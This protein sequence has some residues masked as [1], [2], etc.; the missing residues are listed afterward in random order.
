MATM[1]LQLWKKNRRRTLFTFLLSGVVYGI[2]YSLVLVTIIPYLEK[3]VKSEKPLF[4]YGLCISI[5]N[6]VAVL[7]DLVIGRIA[8]RSRN[9]KLAVCM[10]LLFGILGNVLYAVYFSPILLI[11]GRA[12]VGIHESIWSLLIGEIMRTYEETHAT[13]VQCL[14]IA[15][16]SLGKFVYSF[17]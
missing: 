7:A 9:I 1:D 13:R 6:L 15:A 4:Y 8:D 14:F 12:I 11:I 2:D 5:Y 3:L 10:C 16:C 17:V